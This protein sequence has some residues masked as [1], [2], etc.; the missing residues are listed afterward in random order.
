MK[1]VLLILLAAILV[2]SMLFMGI[3]CKEAATAEA[4]ETTEEAA[5]VEEETTEEAEETAEPETKQPVTLQIMANQDWVQKSFM[6]KSWE[7]YEEATGNTLEL[8]VVPI[9]SGEEFMLTKF[10][11]GDIP[12]IFMHFGGLGL[13]PYDPEKNFVDFSDAEWVDDIMPYVISQTMYGGKLYGLPFWEASVSGTLYNKEIFADLGIDIPTTQTE[14]EAAC[15]TIKNAGIT[16]IYMAFK[17]VWPLSYM[18]CLDSMVADE[19]VLSKLNSNEITY[20]DIPEFADMLAWYKKMADNGYLGEFFTTNTWDGCAEGIG[21]GE[22]AMIYVW[23]SWVWEDLEP[24]YPGM[25]ES[26]GMMP[27]FLGTPE[28]GNYEGPAIC[29]TYAN[30]NSDNVDAAIEFINFMATSEN[31]NMAFEGVE[32][33]PVFKSQTSN[34]PTAQFVEAS[35]VIDAISNPPITWMDLIGFTEVESAK[36]IQDLMLGNKTIEETIAAMDQDRIENARAQQAEGF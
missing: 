36:Y 13:T 29:N 6:Q 15:E 12:D 31:I 10:A 5:P 34:V 17:D 20:A 3:G 14:F 19:E 4:E 7:A 24:V 16:P 25:S 27:A 11:T 35:D 30:K 21:S 22:Y 28:E 33:A 18:Y 8:I 9:D 26:I 2:T 32:C 23:D 1:R